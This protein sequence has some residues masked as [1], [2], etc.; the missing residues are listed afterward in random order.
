MS[1]VVERVDEDA[2]LKPGNCGSDI[3]KLVLKDTLASV[4]TPWQD[5]N[6]NTM[7][8]FRDNIRRYL[9]SRRLKIKDRFKIGKFYGLDEFDK[10][11]IPLSLIGFHLSI[12]TE[13]SCCQ[14]L[15][16]AKWPTL[17]RGLRF[18]VI[19]E[20]STGLPNLQLVLD[21]IVRFPPYEKLKPQVARGYQKEPRKTICGGCRVA[22]KGQIRR[23]R[24]GYFPPVMEMRLEFKQ[25]EL[26]KPAAWRDMRV[27]YNLNWS[28]IR[29]KFG[30]MIR[31]DFTRGSEHFS[32]YVEINNKLYFHYG[33][34]TGL[35]RLSREK[36]GPKDALNLSMA[37]P[38]GSNKVSARFYYFKDDE[39]GGLGEWTNV[40]EE[41]RTAQTESIEIDDSESDP[42]DLDE[43]DVGDPCDG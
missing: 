4:K 18:R 5:R 12:E 38:E 23:V 14:A 43:M 8:G 39:K 26:Q 17:T 36:L 1:D 30:G 28:G 37:I 15:T 29:Y 41:D 10:H 32:S 2:Y 24:V 33:D 27:P 20:R 34:S 42:G 16:Q 3:L 6:V 19:N 11:I 13:C 40:R 9:S 25:S 7:G 31:Q 22:A 35:M 21:E